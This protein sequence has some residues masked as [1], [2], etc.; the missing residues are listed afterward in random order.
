MQ[1]IDFIL[2][3]GRGGE[4]KL[5]QGLL[6]AVIIKAMEDFFVNTN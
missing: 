3:A 4:A 5:K 2:S 6:G 1:S